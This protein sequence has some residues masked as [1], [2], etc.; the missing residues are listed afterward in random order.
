MAYDYSRRQEAQSFFLSAPQRES[1]QARLTEESTVKSGI[2]SSFSSRLL[3]IQCT[4]YNVN[5]SD[6]FVIAE[7]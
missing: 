6:T 3:W 7:I 1:L 2:E 5:E 4:I